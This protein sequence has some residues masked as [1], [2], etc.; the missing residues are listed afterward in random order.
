MNKEFPDLHQVRDDEVASYIIG[1]AFAT[2]TCSTA[3]AELN[4]INRQMNA[5]MFCANVFMS[6]MSSCHLHRKIPVKVMVA[7]AS[8]EARSSFWITHG[9]TAKDLSRESYHASIELQVPA[10]EHLQVCEICA[11]G[12]HDEFNDSLRDFFSAIENIPKEE[13]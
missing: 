7:L 5:S 8:P 9:Y 1:E 11:S 13:H 2:R 10:A 6:H 3:L 4:A 12:R